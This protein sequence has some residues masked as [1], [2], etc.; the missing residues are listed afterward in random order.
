MTAG[1]NPFQARWTRKGNNLCLG[2]WEIR[3]CERLLEL[4]AARR[5]NDM[6][7]LGIYNFMD[8]DDPEFTDG[9]SEDDWLLT[10]MEWLADLFAASDIPIDEQH[11]RWLYQ[12]LN[13]QDW[14]C[15]SCGG[16]I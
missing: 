14:R 4:P 5:D 1:S 11:M 3:Y 10:N 13:A 15:G 16:C 6:G 8:P 2:Q 9:L 7:T 12:A